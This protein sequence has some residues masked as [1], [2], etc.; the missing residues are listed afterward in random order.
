MD[1][2]RQFNVSA[3]RVDIDT[4]FPS[5]Q[6]VEIDS[7]ISKWL[8]ILPS[9]L[10]ELRIT[11][12][13]SSE[14]D[15]VLTVVVRYR[16]RRAVIYVRPEWHQWGACDRKRYIIHELVHIATDELVSFSENTLGKLL[17][18]D[19]PAHKA[20]M[21]VHAEKVEAMTEDLKYAFMRIGRSD[22]DDR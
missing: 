6:A 5:E 11:Q 13:G 8:G 20:L 18:D 21:E 17:S 10:K 15:T 7:I 3:L 16:Y 4:E 12:A 2:I 1:N 22:A 19:D 9:W 14:G